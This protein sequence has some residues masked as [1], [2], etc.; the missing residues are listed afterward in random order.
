MRKLHG[1]LIFALATSLASC[2]QQSVSPTAPSV[3]HIVP[4]P[5]AP[6]TARTEWGG[7]FPSLPSADGYSY[8]AWFTFTQGVT[9][10]VVVTIHSDCPT[11]QT[12]PYLHLTVTSLQPPTSTLTCSLEGPNLDCSNSAL[13]SAGRYEVAFSVNGASNPPGC[14]WRMSLEY[15]P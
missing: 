7:T 15:Q 8:G 5:T 12:Y 4:V 13:L 6:A 11:G 3:G 1:A 9:G 10:R 14:G 2:T